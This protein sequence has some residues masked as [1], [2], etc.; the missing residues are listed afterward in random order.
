MDEILLKKTRLK[1]QTKYSQK[2][3]IKPIAETMFNGKFDKTLYLFKIE[4]RI[5]KPEDN[6]ASRTA[7]SKC[8]SHRLIAL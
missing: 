2:S 5:T 3:F 4:F 6:R 8:N 1:S 7:A